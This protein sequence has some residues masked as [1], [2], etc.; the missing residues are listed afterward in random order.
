MGLETIHY[1]GAVFTFFGLLSLSWVLAIS[2]AGWARA[3]AAMG[4][5]GGVLTP[6]HRIGRQVA[7]GVAKAAPSSPKMARKKAFKQPRREPVLVAGA[8]DAAAAAPSTVAKARTSRAAKKTGQQEMFD[9]SASNGFQLPPAR[10]EP[11]AKAQLGPSKAALEDHA[12]ALENVLSDFSVN[13]SI[14]DVR[15]GPVVT[16]YDLNPAPGTKSQRVISWLMILPD[17]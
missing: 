16:R 11:S 8:G 9:F 2:R 4:R 15:F 7:S 6:V 14:T 1:V 5:I 10:F 3:A 12:A 13:G 17:Q